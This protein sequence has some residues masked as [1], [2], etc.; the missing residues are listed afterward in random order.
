MQKQ[1]VV[2]RNVIFKPS[3]DFDAITHKCKKGK[4]LSLPCDHA[5]KY[6]EE[7]KGKIV[8]EFDPADQAMEKRG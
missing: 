8:S 5:R 1:D 7:G 3:Q 2:I 6:E 4:E